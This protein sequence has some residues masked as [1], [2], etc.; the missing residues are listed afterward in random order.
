MNTKKSSKGTIYG[1]VVNPKNEP[2][3]DAVVMISDDSPAHKDIAALTNEQGE[4]SLDIMKPG[5]YKITVNAT[6][7]ATQIKQAQIK[8]NTISR[9][10]FFLK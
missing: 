6:G 7:F 10:D 8:D 5:N 2:I 9:L 4:Y 3:F 1:K